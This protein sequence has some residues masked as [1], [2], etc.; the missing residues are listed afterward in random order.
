[1][2]CVSKEGKVTARAA[3]TLTGFIWILDY[4]ARETAFIFLW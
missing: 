2:L 3:I 1:M 4:G